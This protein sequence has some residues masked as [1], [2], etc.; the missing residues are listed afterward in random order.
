M[1]TGV[2]VFYDIYFAAKILAWVGVLHGAAG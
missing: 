2:H 1:V